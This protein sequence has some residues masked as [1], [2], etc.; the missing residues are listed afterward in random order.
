MRFGRYSI[1]ILA[2]AE[3]KERA[4]RQA[5]DRS[6]DE[7]WIGFGPINAAQEDFDGDERLTGEGTLKRSLLSATPDWKPALVQARTGSR[8]P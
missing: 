5:A 8:R 6:S 1:E 4:S 3:R 2:A 7:P